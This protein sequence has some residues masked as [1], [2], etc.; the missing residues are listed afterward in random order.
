MALG[1]ASMDCTDERDIVNGWVY[2]KYDVRK[3]YGH[4]IAKFKWISEDNQSTFFIKCK[5][6]SYYDNSKLPFRFP[7]K[8]KA[9]QF[10]QF[11]TMMAVKTGA[12]NRKERMWDGDAGTE[13]VEVGSAFTVMSY[14]HQME[15]DMLSDPEYLPN[16]ATILQALMFGTPQEYDEH[17]QHLNK[18]TQR[19]YQRP[20]IVVTEEKEGDT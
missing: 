9:M 17:I 20:S 10:K 19:N 5:G 16:P 18:Y 11:L 3:S 12:T 6:T 1:D 13:K 7:D 2:T 15:M 8:V 14:T 4:E